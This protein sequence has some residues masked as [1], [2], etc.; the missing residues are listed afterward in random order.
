MLAPSVVSSPAYCA[1]W[2]DVIAVN[3]ALPRVYSALPYVC[4]IGF[5]SY[6]PG[7][8]MMRP[9]LLAKPAS[10]RHFARSL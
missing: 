6:G 8:T 1:E 4:R 10:N 5:A 9:L 3:E 7:A 2:V